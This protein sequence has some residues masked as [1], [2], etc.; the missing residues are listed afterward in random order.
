VIAFY[1]RLI[2]ERMPLTYGE[3][4]K[5][6]TNALVTS[7]MRTECSLIRIPDEVDVNVTNGTLDVEVENQVEV[8]GT[9]SIER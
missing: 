6:M 4:Y 8:S 7:N 9:V 3:W 5:H 2:Y 1:D